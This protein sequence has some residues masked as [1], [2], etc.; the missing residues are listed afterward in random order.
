MRT[1]HRYHRNVSTAHQNPELFF[2]L[3]MTCINSNSREFFY[4]RL[5]PPISLV[6]SNAK[7]TVLQFF[8]VSRR[9]SR[10]R[11]GNVSALRD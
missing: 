9:P 6:K 3:K 5:A 4:F 1:S 7:P 11:A 2:H 10:R 8:S